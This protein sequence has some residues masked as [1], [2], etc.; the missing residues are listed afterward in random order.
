MSLL[1]RRLGRLTALLAALAV[2]LPA[3]PARADAYLDDWHPYQTF[4]AVEW[5]PAVPVGTLR[6]GFVSTTGWLGGGFQV[7]VGVVGRLAVGV[8][9]DWNFF[10]L[11][12]PNLTIETPD[13]AFTG[14]VYRRL[15]SFAALAT[16]RYYLTQTAVQPYVGLGVG[17]LWIST[18]QRYVDRSANFYTSGLALAP[19]AGFL[20]NVAPR[21]GLFLGARYQVAL[22]TFNG[23]TNPMWVSALAGFAYYY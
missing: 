10:D 16:A 9:G 8:T 20:F 11:T 3:R 12:F 14:A 15:G 7:Q 5:A 1:P 2:L 18:Q 4:W 19:E 13:Y 23:V 6:S 21:V 17:G 22:T